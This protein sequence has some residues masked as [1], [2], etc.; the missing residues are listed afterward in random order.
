MANGPPKTDFFSHLKYQKTSHVV[1]T[2]ETDDFDEVTISEWRNEG[3]SVKYIGFGDG[4]A[5]FVKRVQKLADGISVGEQYAIVAFGAPAS[6][7]LSSLRHLPRLLAFVAYYPPQ[8]P[9]QQH[10][11]YPASVSIIMHLC[12]NSTISVSKRPEVLGLQGSKTRNI[13]RRVESGAG[14]GGEIELGKKGVD[15]EKV[16]TYVYEGVK[17]GF[18]EGDVDEYD[19]VGKEMAFSRSL[20][21]VRKA[22]GTPP[23]DLEGIKDEFID[24]VAR[25]PVRACQ[26]LPTDASRINLPTLTGGFDAE[27]LTQ[28]YRDLFGPSAPYVRARLM[29]RTTG[30]S[31]VV[32]EM[33]ISFRHDR[34][35]QWILPGVPPTGKDVRIVMVS[36]VGIKGG[37]C[38][39]ERVYWDQASV[40]V[41]IGMLSPSL[42]PEG[43]GQR[44][45]NGG[46]KGSKGKRK[47]RMPVV[48]A[49]QA[50]AVAQGED[51]DGNVNALCDGVA[52]TNIS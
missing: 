36:I 25:N 11:T 19:S 47:M 14:L 9:S 52:G 24:E 34:E 16:R 39:A 29:S 28:F 42:V 45:V 15:G 40:L 35:V 23:I 43:F 3:F 46:D 21:L 38:V 50:D 33:L 6:P 32:D 22:F 41:Q 2:G 31:Q 20:D 48:G 1:L 12:A 26:D 27:G 13:Q 44:Q 17:P 49:E 30:T 7:L 10:I 51:W 8:I 4:G 18:A 37:K 5:E